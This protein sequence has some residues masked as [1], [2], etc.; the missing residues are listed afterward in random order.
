MMAEDEIVEVRAL[1]DRV[2]DRA[3]HHAGGSNG[4]LS[5]TERIGRDRHDRHISAW[6]KLHADL[7]AVREE[8]D[9]RIMEHSQRARQKILESDEEARELLAQLQDDRALRTMSWQQVVMCRTMITEHLQGCNSIIDTLYNTLMEIEAQ[10]VEKL[11]G[12]LRDAHRLIVSIAHV[13]PSEAD[14]MVYAEAEEINRTMLDNYV[15][16]ADVK[17][18][19]L[20]DRVNM[21]EHMDVQWEILSERWKHFKEQDLTQQCLD[22]ILDLTAYDEQRCLR[23]D[24]FNRDLHDLM[25]TRIELMKSAAHLSPAFAA[26]SEYDA[27]LQAWQ[28]DMR[29]IHN[30][31]AQM[32]HTLRSDLQR[33]LQEKQDECNA[34][35]TSCLR[36]LVDENVCSPERARLL[37]DRECRHACVVVLRDSHKETEAFVQALD[38]VSATLHAEAD[39]LTE[40]CR[41]LYE[42]WTECGQM[43]A[44]QEDAV[45][46]KIHGLRSLL[47][48]RQAETEQALDMK[49][50]A[51]RQAGSKDALAG[52]KRAVETHLTQAKKL[53]EEYGDSAKGVP[54]THPTKIKA[55]AEAYFERVEAILGVVRLSEKAADREA[56]PRHIVRAHGRDFRMKRRRWAPTLIGVRNHAPVSSS[57]SRT[58]S[59]GSTRTR[60]SEVQGGEKRAVFLSTLPKL[61]RVVSRVDSTVAVDEAEVAKERRERG[62]QP[63]GNRRSTGRNSTNSVAVVGELGSL[64]VTPRRRS[65]VRAS[66][67]TMM[68]TVSEVTNGGNSRVRHTADATASEAGGSHAGRGSDTQRTAANVVVVEDHD[69]DDDDDGDGD[70]DAAVGLREDDEYDEVLDER[71]EF[72]G[73]GM[74]DEGVEEEDAD[75]IG[76]DDA[77]REQRRLDPLARPFVRQHIPAVR[78]ASD[79]AAREVVHNIALSENDALKIWAHIC[80]SWLSHADDFQAESVEHAEEFSTARRREVEAEVDAAIEMHDGRMRRIEEDVH[81]VR[82]AELMMHQHR[83]YQHSQAVEQELLQEKDRSGELQQQ[84]NR[85]A[86]QFERAIDL[87][88]GELCSKRSRKELQMHKEAIEDQYRGYRKVIREALIQYRKSLDVFL[89]RLKE[90]NASFRASFRSFTEN[91][92]FSSDEIVQ[93]KQVITHVFSRIDQI[94]G[95]ILTEL[96]GLES[97]FMAQAN[98][99]MERFQNDYTI[100]HR[101]VSLLE[102][103]RHMISTCKV[104]IQSEINKCDSAFKKL[105]A[106]FAQLDKIKRDVTGEAD[107][108]FSLMKAL[109][110]GVI[111][112]A[113]YLNC[114]K[115]GAPHSYHGERSGSARASRL[116]AAS[117]ASKGARQSTAKST[118]STGK[119]KG[120]SSKQPVANGRNTVPVAVRGLRL[121]V[122]DWIPGRPDSFM[123][124]ITS[125]RI[126]CRSAI[127]HLAVPFYEKGHARHTLRPLEIRETIQ[128]YMDNVQDILNE[129]DDR[130]RTYYEKAVQLLIDL[131]ARINSMFMV[132]TRA[133]FENITFKCVS[134]HTNA[135]H[136]LHG[137]SLAKMRKAWTQ[138]HQ[139]HMARLR[140]Q[141]A[142]PALADDL[143]QLDKEEHK[144]IQDVDSALHALTE[145]S[146]EADDDALTTFVNDMNQM[147]HNLCNIFEDV[148]NPNELYLP[149]RDPT[150][151]PEVAEQRQKGRFPLIVTGQVM[152]GKHRRLTSAHGVGMLSTSLHHRA[153]EARDAS[154]QVAREHFAA[155]SKSRE[156]TWEDVRA[157]LQLEQTTWSDTISRIRSLTEDQA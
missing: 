68:T 55:Q 76:L 123:H 32:H 134:Q 129:L 22:T 97:S 149:S 122:E 110:D 157:G 36:S 66:A 8:V 81:N 44:Q 79:V 64:T 92:N 112:Q 88:C 62:L 74:E 14:R 121:M 30:T 118:K 3:T 114:I 130:A 155:A 139:Q 135:M 61:R 48:Q 93:Y 128:S 115:H 50:D 137:D 75:L 45:V 153:I 95:D 57:Q 59:R 72:G 141:L 145:Q 150:A 35:V 152:P 37:V 80:S 142:H 99:H 91:G 31:Y 108:I 38:D 69:D 78:L 4:E 43:V 86:L 13:L 42:Q 144:R 54:T 105:E 70:G 26:A 33:L 120:Q 82:A 28:A 101:D 96:E 10:R 56:D 17:A 21:E 52:L 34:A 106:T 1:P 154:V 53:L 124:T 113:A 67:Q 12:V 111:E 60:A 27:R 151:P 104:K 116:S 126:T 63:P 58:S 25:Q 90:S 6:N 40:I 46:E 23:L 77:E 107:R 117:H 19:L 94:E 5:L 146:V 73:N 125:H 143:Q 132:S 148:L 29:N 131:L 24:Q 109:S 71:D 127:I 16:Y 140:P 11:R 87:A 83:V 84:L 98:G 18:Q 20:A 103:T 47:R 15:A 102:D 119:R 147:V 51:L 41:S 136:A 85:E 133:V 49:I 156:Q 100:H 65:R 138:Q 39:A 2:V 9:E 7:A 89:R